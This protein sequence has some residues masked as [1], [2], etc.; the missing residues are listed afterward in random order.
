MTGIPDDV[1]EAM[2]DAME[3]AFDEDGADDKD[4]LLDALRAAEA[5]GHKLVSREPTNLMLGTVEQGNRA[6]A[7][8]N[9]R[10][11][12]DAAPGVGKP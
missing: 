3:R 9:W 8:V 5:K 1:I 11:M 10:A 4:A 2:V 12:Y 6:A 7:L